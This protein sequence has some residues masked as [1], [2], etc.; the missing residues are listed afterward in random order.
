MLAAIGHVLMMSFTMAWEILSA[1]ILGFWLSAI[2]Q[3]VVSK[4]EM[5]RLLLDDSPRTIALACSLGASEP[6]RGML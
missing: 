4:E 5:S 3:A 2:I 1:L 6:N